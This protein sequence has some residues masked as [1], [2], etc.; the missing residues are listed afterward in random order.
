MLVLQRLCSIILAMGIALLVTTKPSMA[1]AKLIAV[2]PLRSTTA[3]AATAEHIRQLLIMRLAALD[4]YDARALAEPVSGPLGAAAA[5]IGAEVYVTG[6]VL[7]EGSAY[8]VIL[9]AFDAGTDAAVGRYE[10]VMQSPD[11]LP[12]EPAIA[13]LLAPAAPVQVGDLYAD[14]CTSKTSDTSG[15]SMSVLNTWQFGVQGR[16]IVHDRV[17][18]HG[19]DAPRAITACDFVL[20]VA[21]LNGQQMAITGSPMPVSDVEHQVGMMNGLGTIGIPFVGG[22][23]SLFHQKIRPD[24]D[25]KEDLGGLGSVTVPANG[26][27]TVVV[28]FNVNQYL[29]A[30]SAPNTN[31]TLKGI[32]TT[33]SSSPPSTTPPQ[34]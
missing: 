6:Q 12:Q 2:F 3:L 5:Q 14:M 19:A 7:A 28:T 13:T 21:L 25:P 15:L 4:G 30:A 34:T 33:S 1:S 8:H 20:T 29:A 9:G 32:G 31:V 23:A 16:F 26:S 10:V 11:A 22:F 24:V 18:V 17:L 27:V